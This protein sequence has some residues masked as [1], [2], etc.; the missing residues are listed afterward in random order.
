VD[1]PQRRSLL[2]AAALSFTAV[3]I[4]ASVAPA[5]FREYWG[6]GIFFVVVGALQLGWAE[7]VRRGAA[8]RR[9]LVLGAVGNLAVAVVWLISR[10]VGLPVGP[11]IGQ[12]EGVGLHDVLATADEIVLALIVGLCLAGSRAR[13]VREL[14][15]KAGW[16]LAGVSFVG[17]FLGNHSG[18]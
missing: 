8:D 13:G 18:T 2:P 9:L 1:E 15:G 7:L 14:L 4:H 5:H 12:A 10:T 11:E 6:F 3:L 16:A 17:A